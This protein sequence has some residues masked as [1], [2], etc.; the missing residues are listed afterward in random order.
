MEYA[1][2]VLPAVTIGIDLGDKVSDLCFVNAEG[3]EFRRERIATSQD[4]FGK[5]FGGLPPARVVLECGTHSPWASRT[6]EACGHE[7]IV[8]NPRAIPRRFRKTD[9]RD[10]SGLARDGRSDP[11]RLHPIRHRGPQAQQDLA[12]VRARDA[13]VR[14]RTSLVNHVRGVVKSLGYRLPTCSARSFAEAAKSALPKEVKEALGPVVSIIAQ[15]TKRIRSYDK[16]IEKVCERYPETKT[17]RQVKGVGPMTS[18]TYVLVIEDPTRFADSR[19]VGAYVGL[20]GKK[21]ASGKSDPELRIAKTGDKLLRCLLTISAQHILGPFGEE[22]DLR[23]HGEAIAA[24]GGKNAKKRAV[25]AVARKLAVL[26]HVLWKK[27]AVYEPLRNGNGVKRRQLGSRSGRPGKMKTT[28][29]A[30]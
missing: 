7:V 13:V 3:K 1:T 4:R 10:A 29:E 18:L 15:L 2:T 19:D 30:S 28:S 5:F 17:L 25:T 20:V 23:C 27:G 14:A 21:R 16:K 26:L 8:A 6:L 11:E 12:V 22:C 9:E 24:R